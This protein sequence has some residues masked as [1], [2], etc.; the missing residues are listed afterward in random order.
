MGKT[1]LALSLADNIAVKDKVPAI[2]FSLEMTKEQLVK[3]ML[4]MEVG[5]GEQAIRSDEL[6]DSDWEK[7]M[8]GAADIGKSGLIVDDTP[9][10]SIGELCSKCRSYKTECDIQLIIIDY[11]QLMTGDG[12]ADNRRQ[13]ISEISRSLKALAEELKVPI[14]ALSQISRACDIRPDHRP[15]MSDLRES[16]TV[17]QDA[18]VIMFLYRDEYYNKNSGDNKGKAELIIAKHIN[19]SIGT[20]DLLW[21]SN[22]MRFINPEG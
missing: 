6:N 18:D 14:I 3:R 21:S 17:M 16:G 19:G 9:G 13:E 11:L 20:V 7:I 5:V 12:R 8:E 4:A 10:I 1:A 15:I 2:M 22:Y